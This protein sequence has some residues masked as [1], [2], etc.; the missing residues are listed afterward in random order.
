MQYSLLYAVPM[1]IESNDP[2]TPGFLFMLLTH[3]G[4]SAKRKQYKTC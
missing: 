1:Y 3:T 4:W 2:L